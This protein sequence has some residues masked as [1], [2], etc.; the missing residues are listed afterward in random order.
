MNGNHTK[1]GQIGKQTFTHSNTHRHS[2][3]FMNILIIIQK[4][5]KFSGNTQFAKTKKVGKFT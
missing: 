3:D 5:T 4:K 1:L 2:T